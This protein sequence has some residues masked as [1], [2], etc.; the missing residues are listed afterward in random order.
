MNLFIYIELGLMVYEEDINIISK[1]NYN[2]II[3]YDEFKLGISLEFK[4]GIKHYEIII[5]DI[6]RV[7]FKLLVQSL[8]LQRSYF[9]FNL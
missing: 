6:N 3:K 5:Y 9:Y 1:Y 2:F 7:D 8:K 4:I